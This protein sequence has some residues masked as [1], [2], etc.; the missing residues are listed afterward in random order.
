MHCDIYNACLEERI[1]AWKMCGVSVSFKTQC[2]QLP[3][4]READERVRKYSA[5]AEQRTVKRVDRSL[6]A[7]FDRCKRGDTPGF[8]RF[9]PWPSGARPKADGRTPTLKASD[10]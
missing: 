9:K 6:K 4:I 5:S 10:T 1:K 8:P 3:Y 2:A 7:F